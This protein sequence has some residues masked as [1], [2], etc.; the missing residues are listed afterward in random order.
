MKLAFLLAIIPASLAFG[1]I[2]LGPV[3]NTADGKRYY[4]TDRVQRFQAE[5]IAANLRGSL[6]TIHS[7]Q[8]NEWIRANL[9][10]AGGN[11]NECWIGINDIATEGSFVWSSGDPLAYTN[12]ALGEPN[13]FG[14][15][16]DGGV[17]SPGSGVWNDVPAYLTY[18]GIIEVSGPIVVPLEYPTIQAAVNAALDGQ[19][20]EVLPGTYSGG[21]SFGSKKLVVR[22]TQGPEVTTILSTDI[23]FGVVMTGGQG[24]ETVLEGFT[25]AATEP[26]TRQLVNVN[27]GQTV[28]NCRIIGGDTAIVAGGNATITD[29]LIIGRF[30]GVSVI[31]GGRPADVMI[32]NCTIAGSGHGIQAPDPFPPGRYRASVR[33]SIIATAA[34]SVSRSPAATVTLEYCN[35]VFSRESGIGTFSAPP[36]FLNAPG[37]NGTYDLEDDYSLS[38]LSLCID[39]GHVQARRPTASVNLPLDAAGQQRFLD[40]EQANFVAGVSGIVDLGAYEHNP[41][42]PVCAI[43]FNGDGFVDF[44]DYDAFVE[45]FETGC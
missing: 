10:A 18:P 9:A 28:R 25:I 38:P 24:P 20:I 22:S 4:R 2:A 11:T 31:A 40:A 13:D 43:D 34:G 27:G 12:W 36:G 45:A 39:R 5:T 29:C 1:Q 44:F 6:V 35:S 26:N 16:E 8:Q 23:F 30:F 33:N 21:F 15:I 19:V 7:Q 14:G 32:Q 37:A 41:Q 3:M 17:M 42:A